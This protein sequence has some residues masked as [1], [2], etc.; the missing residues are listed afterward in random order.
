MVAFAYDA[1]GRRR[2]KTVGGGTTSFLYDG[3]SLLQ[4]LSGGS[5]TA[6]LLGGAGIDEILTRTDGAGTTSL[7]T[8]AL[9]STVALADMSG[10][11]Q[12][13]YSYE[14]FGQATV[15][16]TATSNSVAFAGRDLFLA[17][18]QSGATVW[19]LRRAARSDPDSETIQQRL[20]FS[21]LH[22]GRGISLVALGRL[23]EGIGSRRHA[24]ASNG[25]FA[26]AVSHLGAALGDAR[27][28]GASARSGRRFMHCTRRRALPA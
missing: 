6:N 8:D 14:P 21:P 22:T 7:L 19:C 23:D 24:V 9:G 13:A 18:K 10:T 3:L 12:T 16:G 25:S 28:E 2:E 4:E 27:A 11:L 20:A 17:L 15:T 5:P 1:I 26:D